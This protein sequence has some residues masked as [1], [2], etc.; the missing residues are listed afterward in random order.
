MKL[1]DLKT[2]NGRP[3]PPNEKR[4]ALFM[5]LLFVVAV[6]LAAIAKAHL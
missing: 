3:T 2:R 1:E 4:A 5:A 6:I